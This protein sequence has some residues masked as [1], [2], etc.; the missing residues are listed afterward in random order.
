MRAKPTGYRE[1]WLE[2]VAGAANATVAVYCRSSIRGLTRRFAH[3][4]LQY[5]IRV[6]DYARNRPRKSDT[7]GALSPASVCRR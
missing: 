7:E 1:R 3:G 4:E 2:V 6:E 5:S